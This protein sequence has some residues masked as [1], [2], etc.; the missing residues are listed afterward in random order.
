MFWIETIRPTVVALHA[1]LKTR[2]CMDIK[3]NIFSNDHD[4]L[5]YIFLWSH[6]LIIPMYRGLLYSH[7]DYDNYSYFFCS[8]LQICFINISLNSSECFYFI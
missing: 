1:T 3:M 2:E 7:Y 4:R 5:A 8:Y 6:T